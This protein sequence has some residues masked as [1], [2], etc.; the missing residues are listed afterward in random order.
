MRS[1]SRP[2]G[3]GEERGRRGDMEE[4]STERDVVNDGPGE[5]QM[6]RKRRERERER[7]AKD[8]KEEREREG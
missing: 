1:S 2:C 4:E 5:V 3:G 6:I 8:K 7:G